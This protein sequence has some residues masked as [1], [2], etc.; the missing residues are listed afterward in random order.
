MGHGD[1]WLRRRPVANVSNQIFSNMVTGGIV[2]S[3]HPGAHHPKG[4]NLSSVLIRNQAEAEK[5]LG[6]LLIDSEAPEATAVSACTRIDV[7]GIWPSPEY[8]EIA[9]KTTPEPGAALGEVW[10]IR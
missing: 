10:P 9:F 3:A 2:S 6:E 7:P 4:Q 1:I 8:E 5:G